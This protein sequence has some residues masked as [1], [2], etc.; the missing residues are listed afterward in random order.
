MREAG[1]KNFLAGYLIKILAS[2]KCHDETMQGP[3]VLSLGPQLLGE[4]THFLMWAELC[5]AHFKEQKTIVNAFF[6]AKTEITCS[7]ANTINNMR[8]FELFDRRTRFYR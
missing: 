1:I 4:P 8:L 2:K 7:V 5:C 6:H 3:A